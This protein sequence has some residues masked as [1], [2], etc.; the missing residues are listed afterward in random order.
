MNIRA[1]SDLHLASPANRDALQELP[2]YPD[3]WL[4]L[5]GDVAERFDHVRLAFATLTEK[6]AKVFWVPGNHDL[7]AIPEEGGKGPALVGEERYRAL[8]D[9]ARAYGVVTPEDPFEVWTGPGG[10]CAIAPLFL[11]YDY[12]F[13]PDHIG[14]HEVVAWAREQNS[15]CADEMFL[16]PAPFES[17]EAWC[18]RRCDE[19]EARLSALPEGMET[20][21]VNH[22]PMREDLIRI[23]RAPRFSPWCGTRRT[24][25][26]HR[27]FN[28]RVVIS[29]HIHIRRT[30]WRH[31]TRFEEVSLGYPRQ[32][33]QERGMAP[34]L[35]TIL[36]EEAD[37]QEP[38]SALR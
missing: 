33:D 20:I 6:F 38:A 9:L 11:L 7:W 22:F 30:D 16:N 1:I 2:F 34:Y 37:I 36:G 19:A 15:V 5:A 32:W 23:P 14:R 21:L 4:I 25:D 28:A 10:P 35:R 31:G 13:R 18:Q 8:V 17:R 27:R 24:E 29:G 12:S 3:D 26:W